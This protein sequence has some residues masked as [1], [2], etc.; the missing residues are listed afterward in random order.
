MQE[1]KSKKQN[2][3]SWREEKKLKT[4]NTIQKNA[5]R[6]FAKQ[7]YEA[8]TIEEI[9]RASEISRITFFRYFPTKAE[10]VMG[11]MFE[12]SVYDLTR[13]QPNDLTLIQALLATF[14]KL[15]NEADPQERI[16]LSERHLLLRT[17][18]ELK[19]AMMIRL[20]EKY[21]L[22]REL[23]AERTG[24]SADDFTVR[25]FAGAITGIGISAWLT[26]EQDSAEGFI[27]RYFSL[28][29]ENLKHLEAGLPLD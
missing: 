8:T 28:L 17:I 27:E 26:A 7:G 15:V 9:A 6:L 24:K 20:A 23:L 11:D 13:Q 3:L 18:P 14:Q 1:T 29:A 2:N 4:K 22:I 5:L 10:V 25:N 21:D 12:L 19:T 16:L